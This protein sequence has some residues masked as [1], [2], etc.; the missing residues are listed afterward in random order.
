MTNVIDGGEDIFSHTRRL[1]REAANIADALDVIRAMI[2]DSAWR[3]MAE[4]KE[5]QKSAVVVPFTRRPPH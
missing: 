5:G 4:T 1:R 2:T 3:P